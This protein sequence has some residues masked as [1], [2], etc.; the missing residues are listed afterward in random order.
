MGD[1][2]P[3][4]RE[5]EQISD[6]RGVIVSPVDESGVTAHSAAAELATMRQ[7]METLFAR[8]EVLQQNQAVQFATVN[9]RLDAVELE[10]PLIQ[11]QT[12]L[13]MRDLE[14]RMGSEIEESARL[15][16]E[17][18]VASLQDDVAGKFGSLT[19]QIENQ[20]KELLSMRES[21]IL[22]ESRLNQVI[23]DIER[24]S[25]NLQPSPVQ[26]ALQP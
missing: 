14:S 26:E 6:A 16:A 12:A 2:N 13:R 11:E 21:K 17:A 9:D 25:G 4:T 7:M 5:P 8:M 23:E 10:V 19:S 18:V 20:R 24:L 22:A 15:A 3:Q 1:P